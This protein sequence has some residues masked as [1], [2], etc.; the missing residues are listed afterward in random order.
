MSKPTRLPRNF[1]KSFKPERQYINAL[2]HYAAAGKS[3]DYQAI[4]AHTGIPMGTSSG[5]VPAV[6]DYCRGMGFIQL[7]GP[8]RSSEKKPELTPFGRITLLEDPFLKMNITQWI[9]HLN[10]CGPLYGAEVWYQTFFQATQVLGMRFGRADL[11]SH[12]SLALGVD[13]AGLIGPLLGMYDDEAAFGNCGALIE[14]EGVIVRKT[15]PISEEYGYGY[16]AWMLQLISDHYPD[17]NQISTTELDTR[18]GW[19]TIPGWDSGHQHRIL[20]LIER[21]GLIEVD[22]HMDPWL[23]RAKQSPES[24]WRRIYDDLM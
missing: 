9:A 20:E 16:G 17:N 1:H 23:L 22:R 21:K 4:A 11:E 19:R 2:L 10:L 12:L 13:K 3:G 18:A 15:A 6:I 14:S 5:K 8:E 7:S 24:A